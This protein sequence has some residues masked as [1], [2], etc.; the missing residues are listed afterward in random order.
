MRLSIILFSLLSATYLSAQ[1]RY[2]SFIFL[3]DTHYGFTRPHFRGKD[4]VSAIAPNRAMIDAINRLPGM[5]LPEDDGAGAG[6]RLAS[7]DGL[8][9][10][11]DLVNRQEPPAP[12]A[13]VSW[14]DFSTDYFHRLTIKNPQGSHTPLWLVPGNHDVSNAIGYY[15]KMIPGKD[16]ASMIGIYNFEMNPPIPVTQESFSFQQHKT[17]YTRSIGSVHFVFMT[18][19]PDSTER[20][21]L[22]EAVSKFPTAE[23]ILL[24]VHDPA[25][26][27]PKHFSN[28]NGERE[29]RIGDRFE[30][31]IEEIYKDSSAPGPTLL[32]ETKWEEWLL[33]HPS[34]KAYFHGHENYTEFYNYTGPHNKLHLPVFR[35]DSPMKGRY[36]AKDETRLSFQVVIIDTK[37]GQLTSRECLWNTE[38]SHPEKELIWGHSKTISIK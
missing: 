25:D 31:V 35:C 38:P 30:N 8:V 16:P 7:F 5:I 24:F 4:S 37:T 27:D 14:N 6:T 13:T 12:A 2:V 28:P 34:V 15:R 29:I 23:P 20:I 3:S 26:G 18:I 36:S 10:T 9:I 11:G 22:D 1:Q 33:K 32:E 17:H 19:W 21:W